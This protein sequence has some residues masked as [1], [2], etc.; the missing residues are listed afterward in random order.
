MNGTNGSHFDSQLRYVARK[1]SRWP[2]DNQQHS[3]SRLPCSVLQMAKRALGLSKKLL[4]SYPVPQHRT[5]LVAALRV[6][7]LGD[8]L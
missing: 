7:W 8:A 2:V 4:S 5:P 1:R 6:A 3:L